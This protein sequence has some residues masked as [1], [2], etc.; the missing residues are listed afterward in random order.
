MNT[1]RRT[2]SVVG[3]LVILLG[4]IIYIKRTAIY[5]EMNNLKLV[6][7]PEPFTELYF[8]NVPGLPKATVAKQPISFSFTIHNVEYKP[9]VYPYNAYFETPDGT[10]LIFASNSVSLASNDSTTITA[11]F[12]PL[13]SNETGEVVVNLTNL[14]QQIDFLLPDTNP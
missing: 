9:V 4:A 11:S 10:E 6:P 13:A 3:L 12:T 8:D 7:Q 2:W 14:N 5:N 1:S